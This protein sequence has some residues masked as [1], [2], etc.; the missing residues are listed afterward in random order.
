MKYS[1]GTSELDSL[2]GEALYPGTTIAVVGHPGAGKTT[3][4][5]QFCHANALLGHK[6]L[7]ISFQEEKEKLYR[8]MKRLGIDLEE[9]EKKGLFKHVR[10]PMMVVVDDVI[11]EISNLIAQAGFDA[12]VVDSVNALLEP[13]KSREDQRMVL[14]NYF[15]ELSRTFKGVLVLLAE[16]PMGEERINLGAIE[17]IADIIIILKHRVTHG[18]LTRIL[19][20]RKAR[21][22]PLKVVE[23]PFNI[24]EGFGVRVYP[25]PR[26]EKIALG[27][28]KPLS[29]KLSL[30][31]TVFKTLLKGENVFITYSPMAR[32]G[33]PV[34]LLL[35]FVVSN[36][37]KALL[38]SYTY[39]R[40]EVVDAVVEKIVRY[41]GIPRYDA[42]RLLTKYLRVESINPVGEAI[43]ALHTSTVQMVEELNPDIVIYHGVEVFSKVADPREYWSSLINELAWYKN[44]GVTVFRFGSC[45]PKDW[46]QMNA[47]V[48]DAVV[49]VNYEYR[50][51]RV[52]PVIY[53]WR[54]AHSPSYIE[55]TD[56][57]RSNLM[58]EFQ[59]LVKPVLADSTES[60]E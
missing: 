9:L 20:V 6:C 3:F 56:P 15:Y 28:G 34:L 17:F 22:A 48:S 7:Y 57:V 46:C 35:D 24:I 51:G 40:D 53:S 59:E 4:A 58:K 36:N 27:N 2:I 41:G 39:S 54:R 43:I 26:F 31:K 33:L 19:E 49:R 47:A 45:T 37:A 1:T 38:I 14:Q 29:S 44:K 8:N 50:E 42:Q 12:V 18:L 55:L 11:R 21:G 23:I 10:L 60:L 16:I 5:S 25:P 52:T 30:T 32:S 13:L